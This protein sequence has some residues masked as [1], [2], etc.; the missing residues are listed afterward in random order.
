MN[1]VGS[2]ATVDLTSPHLAELCEVIRTAHI[3]RQQADALVTDWT[4]EERVA[5]DLVAN[6]RDE[7]IAL[8][9]RSTA[10]SA[11]PLSFFYKRKIRRTDQ[12]YQETSVHAREAM[13]RLAAARDGLANA[14][15]YRE[16]IW[17]DGSFPLSGPVQSAWDAVIETFVNL[18]NSDRIWDVTA[19]RNKRAGAERSAATMVVDRKQTKLSLASLPFFVPQFTALRWHNANGDDIYIY[20]GLLLVARDASTFAVLDLKTVKV[21]FAMTRFAETEQPPRDSVQRG[22]TWQFANKDGSRDARYRENQEIPYMV[23]AELGFKSPTGLN[24][25][26]M[27][28]NVD[29]AATFSDALLEF[30]KLLSR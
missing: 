16:Q 13:G 15:S 11:S 14:E 12:K 8:K 27:I 1:V 30:E 5:T 26:F 3:R 9:E 10:L 29:A 18:S 22:S 21:S 28:S 20:P 6:L 7:L 25:E 4:A 2:A 24:E 23:Y 17:V 19:Q